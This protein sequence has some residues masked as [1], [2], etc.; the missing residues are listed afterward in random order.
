MTAPCFNQLSICSDATA[1]WRAPI[2]RCDVWVHCR[3]DFRHAW[4]PSSWSSWWVMDGGDD[5]DPLVSFDAAANLN[6]QVN[7]VQ[8]AMS[9]MHDGHSKGFRQGTP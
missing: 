1:S 7:D 4:K 8:D 3:G 6:A 9:I 5:H 2:T